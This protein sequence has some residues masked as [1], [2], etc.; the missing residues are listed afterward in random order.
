MKQ[1]KLESPINLEYSKAKD[2]TAALLLAFS[3]ALLPIQAHAAISG[4]SAITAFFKEFIN[5]L[6]FDWGY[7][8][9][10][11][12]L[13]FKGYQWKSGHI[14]MKEMGVWTA[15]IVLV[16]FAPNIVGMI[17]SSSNMSV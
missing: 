17:R 8:I 16:F 4:F 13:A 1:T 9:G 12:T 14:N 6:I 5:M 2:T 3:F 15:G 10:I 7:Y 11:I